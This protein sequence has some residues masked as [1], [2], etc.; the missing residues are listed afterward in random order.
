MGKLFYTGSD[1]STAPISFVFRPG[2]TTICRFVPVV[3]DTI[4]LEGNET[5]VV[6]LTSTTPGFMTTT[7]SVPVIIR[8][9]DGKDKIM[10]RN[11]VHCMRFIFCSFNG[12]L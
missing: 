5:F 1:F 6:N 7:P 4:A 2:D 11:W 9:N 10:H 8:D 3:D 12:I